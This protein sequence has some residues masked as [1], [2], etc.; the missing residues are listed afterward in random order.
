MA[1]FI[2]PLDNFKDPLDVKQPPPSNMIGRN[3]PQNFF[4]RLGA[5]W[6]QRGANIAD[7]YQ[8][9][10]SRFA[11]SQPEQPM[12]SVI[13]APH[14]VLQTVGQVAGGVEDVVAEGVRSAYRT[15]VPEK[16][17]GKVSETI[18]NI[19]STPMGQMGVSAAKKGVEYWEKFKKSYPDAAGDIEAVTNIASILPAGKWGQITGKEVLNVAKDAKFAA[20]TIS[21]DALDNQ[22]K[23]VVKGYLPKSMQWTTA[24]KKTFSKGEK[25][26]DEGQAAIEGI[27]K[28]KESLALSTEK[29]TVAKLPETVPEF[30]QALEQTK[31]GIYQ[32]YHGMAV[33][34][35]E[36]G[37]VF[38]AKPI[39]DKLDAL[40]K[41]LKFN[42]QVRKYAEDLKA[43]IM[44]L[45]GQ[46]PEVIEARIKDLNGSLGGFYEGRISK[47]KAQVDASVASLM[48]KEQDDIIT[49]LKGEGYKDLKK[50]Y[51]ALRSIEDG[52]NAKAMQEMRKATKG[53]FDLP[54]VF[55]GAYAVHGL[56]TMSPEVMIS[57]AAAKGMGKLYKWM[58]SPNRAVKNMFKEV[59][60]IVEKQKAAQSGYKPKSWTGQKLQD[61]TN[62]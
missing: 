32:Q 51:G 3:V 25:A 47:A 61:I 1:D 21:K 31:Q 14:R 11:P 36:G 33:S 49:N 10:Q 5:S 29:G 45:D 26:L 46:L 19:L 12:E 41:D 16:T 59:D 13:R 22:V 4:Q 27:I 62:P 9:Q 28:N 57:A 23:S 34:A 8:P 20:T 37:A 60:S 2:D 44:E 24:G 30:A 56:L 7:I 18:K 40:S 52:V 55:T 50:Q 48:R 54:D 43:E 53:I 38:K 58:N 6:G 39:I 15:F 35:G 42:P 17:Q